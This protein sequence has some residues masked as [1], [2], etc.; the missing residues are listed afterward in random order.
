MQNNAPSFNLSTLAYVL[1]GLATIFSNVLT[2]VF[3]YLFSRPKQS[4][5]IHKT[6]VEAQDIQSSI[7]VKIYTRL[8]EYENTR[9]ELNETIADLENRNFNL[10]YAGRQKDT[11]NKRLLSEIE[12]LD[13][14]VQ[15]ARA[16][17]FLAEDRMP[18]TPNPAA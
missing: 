10:E 8:D 9:R 12:I 4:A 3:T 17:G 1:L 11:E 7:M 5:D 15:K 16:R 2:A 18:G 6:E 13:R 14:Q